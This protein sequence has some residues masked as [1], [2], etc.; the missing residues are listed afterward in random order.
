[1]VWSPINRLPQFAAVAA[2]VRVMAGSGA[3]RL[4]LA[5]AGQKVE[6]PHR[7]EDPQAMGL[8]VQ[9]FIELLE[10]ARKVG[11]ILM[12]APVLK[13][14]LT[15]EDVSDLDQLHQLL[16]RGEFITNARGAGLS[17]SVGTADVDKLI[18][19]LKRKGQQVN[20]TLQVP[21]TPYITVDVK[22]R[23]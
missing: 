23:M 10:K 19:A 3:L 12:R 14:Q 7:F 15:R 22:G 1:M 8:Q 18:L 6:V 5:S 20:I 13:S 4:E 11:Q 16:T 21:G 2:I 17:A 9:S